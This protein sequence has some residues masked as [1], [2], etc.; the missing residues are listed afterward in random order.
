MFDFKS[1]LYRN[2]FLATVVI[3]C[4][5]WLLLQVKDIVL[6][7]FVSFILVS[8]FAP[9][10]KF[11]RSKK[12][13]NILAIL[14][15]YVLIV[16]FLALLIIPLVPFILSQFQLLLEHF[17]DY[18]KQTFKTLNLHTNTS[19]INS[20]ADSQVTSISRNAFD[21]TTGV[22]GGIFSSLT[23]IVISFYLL[24]DHDELK[25]KLAS[26]F[27]KKDQEKAIQTFAH[28]EER[29]GAWL[30]GQLVLSLAVGLMAWVALTIV[31]VS[32]ALPLAVLTGI[33]EIAP[34]IGPIISSVPAI[35]VAFSVSPT[36]GLIVALVFLLIQQIENNIL[37]PKIMERA[38]GLHPVVVIIGVI[39]GGQLAGVMGALLA[40]P[41]ISM[42]SILLRQSATS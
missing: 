40:V 36:L 19:Q 31:G 9:F 21:L 33:L 11:L 24:L 18:V 37:V 32:F 30:R 7:L 17:P 25:H 1:Y 28:V 15:L 3:I 20:F 13:P 27:E 34:I 10:V 12:I 26:L 14:I 4:F 16:A 2:H 42:L 39:V 35:I 8:A 22:F 41:F 6:L 23:I 38:V 5:G 29:L